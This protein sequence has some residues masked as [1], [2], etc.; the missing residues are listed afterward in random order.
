MTWNPLHFLELTP[1]TYFLFFSRWHDWGTATWIQ[2]TWSMIYRMR[3]WISYT[4]DTATAHVQCTLYYTNNFSCTYIV[5]IQ[6]P[7]WHQQ[8]GFGNWG[9]PIKHGTSERNYNGLNSFEHI[10]YLKGA[11]HLAVGG[12]VTRPHA[13]VHRELC[14]CRK[15]ERKP[16][17][18]CYMASSQ[19]WLPFLRNVDD[20]HP[21]EWHTMLHGMIIIGK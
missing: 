13:H 17:F 4:R 18:I 9:A 21:T 7:Q 6:K 1:N 10:C 19:I 11:H 8:N 20:K 3:G 15:K 14:Q 5:I 2:S 12:G 16:A